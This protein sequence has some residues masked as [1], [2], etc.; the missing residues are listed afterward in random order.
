VLEHQHS[1]EV[2]QPRS[3]SGSEWDPKRSNIPTNLFEDVGFKWKLGQFI[4]WSAIHFF[5]KPVIHMVRSRGVVTV[6]GARGKKQVFGA[7]MFEHTSVT[8]SALFSNTSL[9][10]SKNSF[11]G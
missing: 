6:E 1:A 9:L 2:D 3:C 11:F 7:P 10:A 4:A 5:R 8:T